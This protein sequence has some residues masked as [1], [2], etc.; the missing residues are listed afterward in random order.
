MHDTFTFEGSA[1]DDGSPI[2]EPPR[3]TRWAV[4]VQLGAELRRVP[5]GERAIVVGSGRSA[6][7]S[8]DDPTMSARHCEIVATRSGLSVRDLQ[9]TNGTYVGG[10]RMREG[11]AGEGTVITVGQTPLVCVVNEDSQVELG[12]P[13]PGIAGCS[14]PMRQIAAQVRKLAKLS[15]PVLVTGETGVG[16]ELVVRALHGEGPRKEAPIVAVNVATLPRELV[17]SELFGHERGAFTGAVARRAGAFH[18]AE[19][20]TLFLDEIGELPMEA[21]PKLLRALDGYEIRRVGANG[22]GKKPNARVVAA[23]HVALGRSVDAGTFRRD[24]YHRLEV[25]LIEIPPLRSRPGDIVPIARHLLA[26]M[27]PEIGKRDLTA[28]TI[29]KLTSYDW[30]GNVRELRNALSRAAHTATSRWLDVASID[31]AM[32]RP[33]AEIEEPLKLTRRRAEELLARYGGNISAAARH[34]KVPRSTF[35][36]KLKSPR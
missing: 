29:A 10:M 22:G 12:A 18:D 33:R 16:K 30:P 21:Q 2:D 3:R 32:K 19:G 1:D 15:A 31:K 14:M 24:L 26:G 27:E 11:V 25:F 35:R 23:T 28:A 13:L 9:S 4:E 6:D 17:E 20:G 7:L 5:V 8:L 34:A 36:K